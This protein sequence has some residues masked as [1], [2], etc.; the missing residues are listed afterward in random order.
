VPG[1]LLSHRDIGSRIEQIADERPPHVVRAEGLD[2]GLGRSPLAG[3][4]DGVVGHSA[5]FDG[6]AFFDG[7]EQG[8]RHVSTTLEPFVECRA[9]AGGNVRH[10][11]FSRTG[12]FAEDWLEERN[13]GRA[14]SESTRR[15]YISV[16]SRSRS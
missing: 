7:P 6:T 9:A 15:R 14:A 4:E 11:G 3:H 1:Q 16:P 12:P 13:S 10:T 8:S 2:A 5:V